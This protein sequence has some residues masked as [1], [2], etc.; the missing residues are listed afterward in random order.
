MPEVSFCGETFEI[1]AKIGAWPLMRFA[2]L[3]R[4]GVD[5]DD[6]EG[7]AAMHSLIK[8]CI[9]E[10]DWARF[11]QTAET[12]QVEGTDLWAL[13]NDVFRVHAERPTSLPADS[14]AG[15]T[16]TPVSSEDDSSSR[17]IA[18]LEAQGRPDLALVVQDTR[19]FLAS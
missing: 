13:V 1:P 4:S 2:A 6:F 15:P 11:D 17:V 9:A 14:S 7:L 19:E 16:S 12:N 8:S 3:A 5:T 10:D 18:R